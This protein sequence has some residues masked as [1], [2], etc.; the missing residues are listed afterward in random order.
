MKCKNRLCVYHK[1][2]EC[3]IKNEIELDWHGLCKNMIP[4]SITE[5]SLRYEKLVT[6]LQIEDGNH[7]LDN[8]TGIVRLIDNNYS[9]NS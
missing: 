7:C 8:Q 3:I 4:I 5:Q 9:G 2:D 6:K 1:N